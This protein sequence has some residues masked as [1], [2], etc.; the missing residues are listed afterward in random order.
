MKTFVRTFQCVR[1]FAP[2]GTEQKPSHTV[3]PE[4]HR[5][6]STAGDTHT[7]R[8]AYHF[9]PNR[10]QLSIPYIR[11]FLRTS[12]VWYQT[13]TRNT[14]V[15][16]AMV[17]SDSDSDDDSSSCSSIDEPKTDYSKF[18]NKKAVDLD[19]FEAFDGV[20]DEEDETA[21]K[22]KELLQ[23][24]SALGIDKDTQFL[25]GEAKKE[26]ER[27]RQEKLSKE[28]KM[29]MKEDDAGDM[30]AKIKARREEAKA[31]LDQQSKKSEEDDDAATKELLEKAKKKKE[32]KAKKEKKK[33]KKASSDSDS[34]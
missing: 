34:S 14:T 25:A 8:L 29:K 33:K 17:L 30:M 26:E 13:T 18:V 15:H 1:A 20:D 3:I 11:Y 24:R 21:R 22:M 23:L 32:K 16:Y 27:K 9:L 31:R 28:D 7:I 10:N 6:C 12:F 4:S 2:S 19:D 5:F